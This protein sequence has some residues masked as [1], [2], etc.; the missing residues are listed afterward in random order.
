MNKQIKG[1]LAMV[2]I[3]SVTFSVSNAL[4]AD[5]S[6]KLLTPTTDSTYSE[7][8]N[9]G[10]NDSL[11]VEA[12]AKNQPQKQDDNIHPGEKKVETPTTVTEVHTTPSYSKIAAAQPA[13]KNES[14]NNQTRVIIQQSSTTVRTTPKA[15]IQTTHNT[16]TAVKSNT[17]P[18]GTSSTTSV[19]TTAPTTAS[20]TTKNTKATNTTVPT[21]STTSTNTNTNTNTNT[22]N[23]NTQTSS[24][25]TTS[26]AT[27]TTNRG[28]Q[29]SELAKEKAATQRVNNVNNGKNK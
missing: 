10:V 17:T 9:A 3:G 1:A 29:V 11:V 14:S 24:T 6:S 7:N 5:Q 4:L 27:T 18:T 8:Q 25:A 16:K 2:L 12:T 23:T 21:T 28:R 15:A 26:T 22:G 13:L 19:K 20:T